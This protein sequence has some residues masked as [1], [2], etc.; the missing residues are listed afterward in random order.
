MNINA[1]IDENQHPTCLLTQTEPDIPDSGPS[2]V[3]SSDNDNEDYKEL[4]D[5]L[6]TMFQMHEYNFIEQDETALPA[7]PGPLFNTPAT[8][9]VKRT[10][11]PTSPAFSFQCQPAVPS[12]ISSPSLSPSV[13]PLKRCLR[14]LPSMRPDIPDL[15]NGYHP[16]VSPPH[17]HVLLP[18][19]GISVATQSARTSLARESPSHRFSASPDQIDA[20]GV[21]ETWLHGQVISTLGNTFCYSSC[22]KPR[23]AHY[24]IL[25]THLLELCDS[26]MKGHIA[27]QTC[28]SFHFKQATSLFECCTWLVPVLLEHHWY[29]LALDWMDS[30]LR[31][32][33]SLATSKIPHPHLVGFG[34]ML[35]NLISEDLELP[36]YNWNVAPESVSGFIVA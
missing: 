23:H 14:P 33:D 19:Q 1:V 18:S 25:P 21:P 20:L 13:S 32:Y 15:K 11:M 3:A 29:L 26:Y 6:D 16:H 34:E 12:P 2:S 7:V 5:E 28:L 22:S 8:P 31:I 4:W 9:V 10:T 35:L 27:S 24:D 36:D 17:S 30:Q